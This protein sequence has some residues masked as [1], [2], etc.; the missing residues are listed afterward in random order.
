MSKV[1]RDRKYK[2]VRSKCL[3]KN[4]DCTLWA[5]QG[6]CD[7]NER[8]MK[9]MCTPACMSCDY[10]GDTS[11]NCPGL[12]KSKGP[13]WKPGDLNALF[14][15][16]VDAGNECYSQFNPKALSRPMQSNKARPWLILFENF[17]T[18][19]EC[20][21]IIEIGHGQGFER[22][23]RALDFGVEEINAARTSTNTWCKDNCMK[24]PLGKSKF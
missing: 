4:P 21:R 22:S 23:K 9:T 24:D 7:K 17:V 2:N 3:N 13:L 14:E 6:E 10:F 18:D 8:Y 12:P 1:K 16:I 20:D 15:E 11:E 5:A 19:E